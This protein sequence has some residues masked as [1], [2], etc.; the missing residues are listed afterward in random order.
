MKGKNVPEEIMPHFRDLVKII[1]QNPHPIELK[2]EFYLHILGWR[3]G[4]HMN[5][6]E[7]LKYMSFFT[8]YLKPPLALEKYLVAAILENQSL[9]LGNMNLCLVS[10]VNKATEANIKAQEE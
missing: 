4:K 7:L 10:D 2:E 3:N 5:N 1:R 8:M 6:T 9:S